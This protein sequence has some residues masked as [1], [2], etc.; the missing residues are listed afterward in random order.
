ME[1]RER[2]G[3]SAVFDWMPALRAGSTFC[4]AGTIIFVSFRG[5]PRRISIS[6]ALRPII[7]ALALFSSAGCPECRDT[8][9]HV[10]L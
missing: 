3:T 9:S 6:P 8:S 5:M 7:S 4:D 10:S 2:L 1:N